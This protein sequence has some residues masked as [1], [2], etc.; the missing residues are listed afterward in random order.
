MQLSGIKHIHTVQKPSPPSITRTFSSSQTKILSPLNTNSPPLSPQ[1]LTPTLFCV[2]DFISPP[3]PLPVQTHQTN[4]A[5]CPGEQRSQHGSSRESHEGCHLLP[6]PFHC[7]LLGLSCGHVQ[8]LYAR[9]W[10]SCDRWWVDSFNLSIKPFTLPNS[11]E[12]KIK[13]SI[14]KGAMEGKIYPTKKELLINRSE[15]KQSLCRTK[16]DKMSLNYL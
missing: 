6:P 16:E 4:A 5:P 10:I 8:L 14:S 2:S 15:D 7:L 1:P 3:D 11:R 12:Q 9:D 13:T